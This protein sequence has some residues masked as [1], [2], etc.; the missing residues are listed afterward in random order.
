MLH[1]AVSTSR[2][3]FGKVWNWLNSGVIRLEIVL[4]LLCHS[5]VQT[6]TTHPVV[7]ELSL[8]L[9]VTDVWVRQTLKFDFGLTDS[10]ELLSSQ[11]PSVVRSNVMLCFIYIYESVFCVPMINHML[12]SVF[13]LVHALQT[14]SKHH[15][16]QWLIDFSVFSTLTWLSRG[17]KVV[18]TKLD[19]LVSVLYWD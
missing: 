1:G 15:S 5:D 16:E 19:D 11:S 13:C 6:W 17:E 9:E 2:W 10:A 14:D 18:L 8:L 4:F 12:Q 7:F 3:V